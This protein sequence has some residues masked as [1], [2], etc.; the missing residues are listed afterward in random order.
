MELL[1]GG[2]ALLMVERRKKRIE[3][4]IILYC[5]CLQRTEGEKQRDCLGVELK[6]RKNR[7]GVGG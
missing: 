4:N 2:W 7:E 6:K 3:K 1:E 5:G